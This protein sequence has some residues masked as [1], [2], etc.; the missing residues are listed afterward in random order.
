M[1]LTPIFSTF[2]A[3]WFLGESFQWFRAIGMA[4]VTFGIS[5]VTRLIAARIHRVSPA[6]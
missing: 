4:L 3:I 2:L 1:H 6:G 5:M